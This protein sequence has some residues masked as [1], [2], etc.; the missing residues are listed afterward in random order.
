[1]RKWISLC[2]AMLLTLSLAAPA[3]AFGDGIISGAGS[4]I[5]VTVTLTRVGET[6]GAAIE[7]ADCEAA[8]LI[9]RRGGMQQLLD[10]SGNPVGGS[11]DLIDPLC[12]GY[13]LVYQYSA[14]ANCCGLMRDDG[15]LL[16]PVSAAIIQ[17]VNGPDIVNRWQAGLRYIEVVYAGEA[18]P[19]DEGAYLYVGYTPCAGYSLYYDLVRERFVGELRRESASESPYSVCAVGD[20][21]YFGDRDTVYDEN[22]AA[23]LTDPNLKAERDFFVRAGGDGYTVLD[24]GLRELARFRDWPS[25]F[26]SDD[27]FFKLCENNWYRVVDRGGQ[28]LGELRFFMEPEEWGNFFVGM[29]DTGRFLA[30]DQSGKTVLSAAE[31]AAGIDWAPCGFVVLSF[32]WYESGLLCPDGT[33]LR[34][35]GEDVMI[36]DLLMTRRTGG[37][38][39][40]LVLDDKDFS[41][42]LPE[43]AEIGLLDPYDWGAPVLAVIREQNGMCTLVNLVNGEALMKVDCG[44]SGHRPFLFANDCLYVFDPKANIYE[45][46]KV[47]ITY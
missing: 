31:N 18:L 21:L 22:G 45:I 3:Y 35:F 33:L 41:L 15:T 29:D 40:V 17:E 23:I 6:G 9:A 13:W 4:G 30:M 26:G 37:R 39:S 1:M 42:T 43:G 11:Y 7:N 47:D 16:I 27:A 34:G 28:Q 24:S 19:G 44:D 36:T 2:L 12:D 14:G 32:S 8:G 20:K 5:G 38:T 10:R 25:A 46:Y